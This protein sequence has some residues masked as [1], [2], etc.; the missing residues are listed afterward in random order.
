MGVGYLYGLDIFRNITIKNAGKHEQ[1]AVAV[2][3]IIVVFNMLLFGTHKCNR[4]RRH[5][6]RSEWVI[7]F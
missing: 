3:S 7:V 2:F 6:E 1:I 4:F 5:K